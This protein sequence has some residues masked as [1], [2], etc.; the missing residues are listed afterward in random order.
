MTFKESWES[1]RSWKLS[2]HEFICFLASGCI[3]LY[4]SWSVRWRKQGVFFSF[5]L[6]E[7]CS[8]YSPAGHMA[9]LR[10]TANNPMHLSWV[11]FA[12]FITC[13][14]PDSTVDI[15]ILNQLHHEMTAVNLTATGPPSARWR[16]E[17]RCHRWEKHLLLPSNLKVW[18]TLTALKPLWHACLWIW[19]SAQC[20]GRAI[21][22]GR[23]L[24]G[25]LTQHISWPAFHGN[26]TDRCVCDSISNNERRNDEPGHVT[27]VAGLRSSPRLCS[28]LG[29]S[30]L[31]ATGYEFWSC[32]RMLD[33]R[34]PD[35]GREMGRIWLQGPF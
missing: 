26:M 6:C 18:Y 23:S 28:R 30:S 8:R 22:R 32:G 13:L 3:F 16:R 5:S 17:V 35:G 7:I 21:H 29:F 19:K 2:C 9:V 12:Y 31:E 10:D 4:F 15:R 1:A 33:G 20:S 27:H 24:L 11:C 34:R 25:R 14:S